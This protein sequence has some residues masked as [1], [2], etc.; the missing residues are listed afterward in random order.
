MPGRKPFK[1]TAALRRDVSLMKFDGW[2]DD[3]IAAQLAISRTTLL[4]HFPHELE[5]GADAVRR[6]QLAN[7]DRMSKRN[8]AASKAL[9]ARADINPT[10]VPPDFGAVSS[11]QPKLGK[12]EAAEIDA[13]TAERGTSW[14]GILKH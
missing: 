5:F 9:L 8:V 4:K 11:D 1:V 6:R 13:Q 7:L 3:R 12:K 2:S 14:Q 10:G